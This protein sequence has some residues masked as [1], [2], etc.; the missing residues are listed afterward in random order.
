MSALNIGNV[1]PLKPIL[2]PIQIELGKIVI[3]ARIVKSIV[4]WRETYYAFWLTTFSLVASFVSVWVPWGFLLRWTL[5]VAL[6]GLLGPW[7]AVVDHKFF[8][9][10]PD[11]SNAER[12]EKIRA[13]VRA[14][15][16]AMVEAAATR[17]VNKERQLKLK[18]M[19]KY[20]YG[21]YIVRIPMFNEDLFSDLPLPES[22]S[23]AYKPLEHGVVHISER[24]YGQRL[25]G[26]MI[27]Q[28]Q[29]QEAALAAKTTKH[30]SI[31]KLWKKSVPR[32]HR[33]K[34]SR[35]EKT[36]LLA[37]VAQAAYD[38]RNDMV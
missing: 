1:N 19:K 5:R 31:K 18:T 24:K 28:R 25:V 16:G 33:K 10:N 35:D 3:L 37:D 12:D 17:Q 9:E 15:Y 27:P 30:Q 13:R 20:L 21:K 7:M 36:P 26:D 29:I 14:R 38:A 11:P 6:V 4:L 23:E 8:K 22:Y 2:H 34:S 32:R